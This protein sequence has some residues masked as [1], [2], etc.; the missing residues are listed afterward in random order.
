MM[1]MKFSQKYFDRRQN[2]LGSL[3]G[4]IEEMYSGYQVVKL[5][6]AKKGVINK[7]NKGNEAL[8]KTD[9][10]SQFISG[11]MAPLMTVI[12]N[13]AILCVIV[14][15]S[16]MTMD[17]T[18]SFGAVAAFLLYCQYCTQPLTRITQ[19]LTDLQ[20]ICAATVRLFDILESDEMPDES[21][22]TK[23][24]KDP[25]GK[26]EIKNVKFSYPANPKKIII[27]DFSAKIEPGKK[28]AIV[29]QTGAG[30]TTLINLLMRFYDINSGQIKIDDIDINDLKR[31]NIH[32][33]FGMVLQDT[34]LF[35]GTVRENLVYNLQDISDEQ[36]TEVC[37]TCGIFEF[38][39]TMPEGFDTLLTEHVAISAGQ[40]QLMTIAR[41]ML[42]NAPMLILDEATSSVD[43]RT[44]LDIQLAMDMLT[45]GRTSFVIAH[46]LSTIKNA[47]LILV[48]K[49]GDVIESGNHSELIKKH[50]AYYELYNSQFQD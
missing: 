6:K 12:G 17:G 13:V 25:R 9:Y 16:I 5:T 23:V 1:L 38:I 30:K 35:E 26:V 49:N 37:K 4:Y 18:I 3:N 21:S 28:V 14:L 29:G 40:K 7:F 20:S 46:R 36:L 19:Y 2:N 47:N 42:Q 41:A 48:M 39:N 10:M 33:M 44:E 15:G 43:T 24:I 34:W 22:K 11:I 31:E 45:M 50:G 32:D 27:N 8:Y